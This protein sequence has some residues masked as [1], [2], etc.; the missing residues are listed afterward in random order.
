MSFWDTT[1][2]G[3]ATDTGKD[4]EVGGGNFE[5]IPDGTKVLA[6]VEN[7]QW[8]VD[9]SGNEHLSL[10]WTVL[11]PEGFVNRKIFQKLWVTDHDPSAKDEEKAKTKTDKAK[12]MLA[13]I[14]A[15]AGGKLARL[16]KKPTEDE[17]LL[18]FTNKP[19][20]IRLG[21]YSMDDRQNPGEKIRGNWVQAVSAKDTPLDAPTTS[22]KTKKSDDVE[23]DEIPF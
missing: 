11:K 5:P 19:M 22:A 3:V 13:A 2:G 6:S 7:A 14:D 21:V 17:I 16:T 8:K 4:F 23:E 1:D 9:N 12:R 18:A 10:Q 20:V 15:N